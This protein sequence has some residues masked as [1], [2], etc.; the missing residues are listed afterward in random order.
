ML[1]KL[2]FFGEQIAKADL[3]AL[4]RTTR[5]KA[6]ELDELEV[7]LEELERELLEVNGNVEKLRRSHRCARETWLAHALPPLLTAAF[8]LQRADGAA[9]GA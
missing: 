5:E 8:A 6:Y 7:K 4:P 3:V 1:R 9:A 2:R